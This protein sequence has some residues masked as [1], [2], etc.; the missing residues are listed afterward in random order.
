MEEIWMESFG[1]GVR[2]TWSHPDPVEVMDAVDSDAAGKRVE[3]MPHTIWQISRHML[4]WGWMMVNKLKGN[5]I[6]SWDAETNLFPEEDAPPS[7]DAW[8]ANQ[9]AMHELVAEAAN[10]LKDVDPEVRFPKWDNISAADML[11][12]LIG[13]NAYHTAQIVAMRR[14]LGVWEK[15]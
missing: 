3:G 13:H 7:P 2:G 12:I 11:V 15:K 1:R 9:M 14:L 8:R 6:A 10:L 4:Q 5:P